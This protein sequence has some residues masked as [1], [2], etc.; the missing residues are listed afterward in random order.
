MNYWTQSAQN[1]YVAAHRGWSEKYPE[2]T[3]EAFRAAIA[4]GVD[5]VE[6]DIRVTADGELVLIHDAAVDRTTNG[7]GNVCD[8]SLAELRRLDAGAWKGEEFAGCRI[9]TL[10]EFMDLVRDHPTLTV[11]L[12]LKEYPTPGREAAA[13]D[14]C[15]RVLATV[16]RYGFA[17]RCVINTFSGRLHEYIR[18]KY[19]DCYRRHVYFPQSR[20]SDC[21]KDPYAHAYCCCMFGKPVMASAEDFTA[22]KARGVQ[23]WAGAGVRDASGVDEA[24]ACGAELITCNNPDV[25][26]ALLRARGRHA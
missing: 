23:P 6:T 19:G 5:Q 24:I 16:E 8:Y 7:T 1:I 3:M 18:E 15:D 2:N 25:I 13:Y 21:T 4:L 17:D 10:T 20:M 22:M 26:L 14:V 11:D 12:E 9:P